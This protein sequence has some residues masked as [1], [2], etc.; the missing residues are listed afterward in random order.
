M[1][2]T[3][4][5]SEQLQKLRAAVEAEFEMNKDSESA[6]R[7][8]A[9]KDLEDLKGDMLEALR[10][11]LRHSPDGLRARV[12]MWGYD[13]LLEQGKATRDPLAELMQEIPTSTTNATPTSKS[14]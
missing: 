6:H 5:E 10:H 13:K 3:P 7:R 14:D 9:L 1:D 11:S 12:A 4:Q 8:S 2:L